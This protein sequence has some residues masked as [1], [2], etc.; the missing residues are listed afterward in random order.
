MYTMIFA[1]VYL[2][3]TALLQYGMVSVSPFMALMF[4]PNKLTSLVQTKW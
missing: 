4:L 1:C 2:H 3:F